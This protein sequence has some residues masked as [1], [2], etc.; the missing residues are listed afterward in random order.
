VSPIPSC[1]GFETP[2]ARYISFTLHI[3]RVV[4]VVMVYGIEAGKD[5]INSN[6][7][8]REDV[9]ARDNIVTG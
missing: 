6:V 4:E 8:V 5:N 2:S 9:I 3:D 1:V 7:I